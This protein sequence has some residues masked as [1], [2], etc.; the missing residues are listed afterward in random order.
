MKRSFFRVLDSAQGDEGLE[1]V[2]GGFRLIV[3]DELSSGVHNG[4]VKILI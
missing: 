2:R 3:W 1:K 4:E